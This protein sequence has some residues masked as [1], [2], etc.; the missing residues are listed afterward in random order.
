MFKKRCTLC[1]GNLVRGKCTE[2]GLDNNKRRMESADDVMDGYKPWNKSSD[3][4]RDAYGE[5]EREQGYARQKAASDISNEEF[6]N[7]IR[8][9]Q[10]DMSRDTQ[11][12][13]NRTARATTNRPTQPAPNRQRQVTSNE[14]S[15]TK[16]KFPRVLSWI[17]IL[18]FCMNIFG[19]VLATVF[20]MVE[21]VIDTV[22]TDMVG[23]GYD[24]SY[25]EGYVLTMDGSK[26]DEQYITPTPSE[27][28][29]RSDYNQFYE[30]YNN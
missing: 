3:A 16:R 15:G 14:Q 17:I 18:M 1:G 22:T 10:R 8:E 7:K 2:C 20:E 23:E 9:E 13:Q 25:E 12:V 6:F 28:I 27:G 26:E 19:A 11:P 29:A 4:F 30:L 24:F 5:N 21:E